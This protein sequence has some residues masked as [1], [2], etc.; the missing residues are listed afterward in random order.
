MVANWLVSTFHVNFI[1]FC[2]KAN[3][4]LNKNKKKYYI[5][6]IEGKKGY[7]NTDRRTKKSYKK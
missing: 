5:K 2:R 3:Y 7:K 6:K 4:N 1:N